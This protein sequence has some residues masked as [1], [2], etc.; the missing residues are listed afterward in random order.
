MQINMRFNSMKWDPCWESNDRLSSDPWN[1]E[2]ED[3]SP[4]S[5]EIATGSCPEPSEFCLYHPPSFFEFHFSSTL[6]SAPASCKWSLFY[7]GFSIP[8][9]KK[10]ISVA[11][12]WNLPTT[13]SMT[14]RK[15]DLVPTRSQ[16]HCKDCWK[17]S[18]YKSLLCSQLPS[19]KPR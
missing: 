12:N 7:M 8:K 2:T 11:R 15:R 1:L 5:Q 14:F 19:R 3:S 4:C 16:A 13:F 17:P 9:K 6:P 18:K 10:M